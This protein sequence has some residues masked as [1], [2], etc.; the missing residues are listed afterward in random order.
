[1]SKVKQF[2]LMSSESGRQYSATYSVSYGSPR[3][4]GTTSCLS[5][6][7]VSLPDSGLTSPS[8]C[9][10]PTTSGATLTLSLLASFM[11]QPST[12]LCHRQSPLPV[13]RCRLFSCARKLQKPVTGFMNSHGKWSRGAWQTQFLLHECSKLRCFVSYSGMKGNA[14]FTFSPLPDKYV[15]LF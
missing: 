11:Q 10:H 9:L 8:P 5:Y 3:Q 4:K 13:C 2:S 14:L 6:F 1:M 15:S 7:H 12:C